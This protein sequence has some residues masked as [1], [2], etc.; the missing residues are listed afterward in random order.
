M[1]P[2]QWFTIST[3]LWAALIFALRLLNMSLDTLRVIAVVRGNKLA[4]W[5][6]GFFQVLLFLLIFSW[7]Y[8]DLNNLINVFAF[9]AGLAT[10]STTGVWLEE[11]LSLG[12]TELHIVSRGY[13][14]SI[15][16]SLRL[17][18]YAVTEEA[19]RG[20]AGTVTLLHCSIPQ[21]QAKKIVSQVNEIDPHAF[22][23]A[24]KTRIISGGYWK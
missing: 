16:Y 14:E 24:E 15:A 22:I 5:S 7:V 6:F 3:L 12:F 21:A 8:N 18:G 2:W 17:A 1:M 9:C 23:T 11:K 10:G 19:G 20:K 4:A 13:G